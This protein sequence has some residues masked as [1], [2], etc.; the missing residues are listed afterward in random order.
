M[1]LKDCTKLLILFFFHRYAIL[2]P[3]AIPPGFMDGRKATELLIEAMQLDQKDFRLG[4]SK[5]FFKAGVLGHLED[6]RDETLAR[7]LTSFQ[8]QARGYLMRKRF[9]KMQEQR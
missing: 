8:A 1:H 6:L 2:A 9:R 4:H 3:K 7:V 5:V